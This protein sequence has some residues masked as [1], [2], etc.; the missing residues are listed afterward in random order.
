[1]Q[2]RWKL[3]KLKASQEAEEA[4]SSEKGMTRME[5]ERNRRIVEK[6]DYV[7]KTYMNK[8]EKV[9]EERKKSQQEVSKMVFQGYQKGFNPEDYNEEDRRFP[10]QRSAGINIKFTPVTTIIVTIIKRRVSDL[11]LQLGLIKSK[12]KDK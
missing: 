6:Q 2:Q 3:S 7:F 12:S 11:F 1:M 9:Y 10:W 5:I 4:K 8:M